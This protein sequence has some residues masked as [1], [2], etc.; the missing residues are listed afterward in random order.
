MKVW[1]AE[2]IGTFTLVFAG[3]GATAAGV[4]TLGVAFAF[5]SAVAVMVAAVGPISAAHF[6]PAVTVA[7]FALRRIRSVDIFLYWSAQLAG[8]TV[9]LLA[10]RVGYAQQLEAVSF[11]ITRL[12]PD[13]GVL[14]GLVVEAV[15]TFFLMFVITGVVIRKHNLDGLYIG[16]TVGL[17]ALTG[18]ALTGASM[19]PARSF[20]PAL[21]SGVWTNHWVYW[22]GPVVGAVLAAL[23]ARYVWAGFADTDET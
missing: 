5:G 18:G 3:V 12:G 19:N 1:L 17:G 4:D 13:V 8:A 9:A 6:N 22:L 16:A 15:L 14:A 11:G 2:F 20:G 10:L 21:A 7:F 23:T